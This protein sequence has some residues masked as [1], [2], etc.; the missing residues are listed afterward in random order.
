MKTAFWVETD[1]EVR[2][3]GEQTRL[4]TLVVHTL[5]DADHLLEKTCIALL[6]APMPA[7][8]DKRTIDIN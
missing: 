5:N 6:P 2:K 8:A 3:Y 7:A 4:D 1:A